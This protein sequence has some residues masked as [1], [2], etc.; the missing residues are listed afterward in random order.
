M[1]GR[2][3]KDALLKKSEKLHT[4][5]K[6][7]IDQKRV[8]ETEYQSL[9]AELQPR[10]DSLKTQADS[11]AQEFKSLFRSSQEAYAE[12]EK[13]L[14][15]SLSVEGHKVQARCEELN[16]EVGVL[17]NQ[18]KNLRGQIDNFHKRADKLKAEAK[19]YI[20]E[21]KNLRQ[22]LVGNF[23]TSSIVNNTE[24]EGFLDEFPQSVFKEIESVRFSD[25]VSGN[26]F[27]MQLGISHKDRR[28]NKAVVTVFRD[29]F[30][31]EKSKEKVL[32]EFRM[33]I[34]HEIGHTVF[35][36]FMDD[37]LRWKWG[38]MYQVSMMSKNFITPQATFSRADDFCECFAMLK[39]NPEKLGNLDEVRF[40]FIKKVYLDLEKIGE[41]NH[42]KT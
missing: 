8:V 1:K 4:D 17:I 9:R 26:S 7:L 42:E 36:K 30:Q 11:L 39:V 13:A 5:R 25:N 24:V 15:K 2:I 41:K 32:E 14:A 12:D 40:N 31:E 22:T 35:E 21:A 34:A 28:T 27:E 29:P 18:L 10:I 23:N 6:K 3:S 20:N 19:N 37:K 33:T 38:E 16:T